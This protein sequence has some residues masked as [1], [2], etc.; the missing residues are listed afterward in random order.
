MKLRSILSGTLLTLAIVSLISCQENR[1]IRYRFCHQVYFW[2]NNPDNAADRAEFEQG[3]SSLLEI[4][5]IRLYQTGVPEPATSG[6]GVVDGSYTYSLLVFFDDI[7]GHDT[8]QD[9]PVHLKFVKDYQHLWNRVVVYDSV[10][11]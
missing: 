3:L 9:H 6:R 5:E 11:K 2:L 7:N 8:Y 1:K 4:P 10:A